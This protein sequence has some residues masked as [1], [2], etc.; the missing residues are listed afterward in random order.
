MW[1]RASLAGM[2][3]PESATDAA[4][5]VR[6][7]TP[8]PQH[9]NNVGIQMSVPLEAQLLLNNVQLKGEPAARVVTAETH[10]ICSKQHQ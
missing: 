2:A 5:T 6:G 9:P 4:M 1:G 10:H 8:T 3:A 7:S